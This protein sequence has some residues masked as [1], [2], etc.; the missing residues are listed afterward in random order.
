MYEM[1][2]EPKRKSWQYKKQHSI[3]PVICHTNIYA[4]PI[5]RVCLYCVRFG[6]SSIR[7]AENSFHLHLDL[8]ISFPCTCIANE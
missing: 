5:I 8:K 3:E 7:R 1:D 6:Y 2:T 4:N